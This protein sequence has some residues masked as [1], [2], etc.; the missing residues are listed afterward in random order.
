MVRHIVVLSALRASLTAAMD[1]D[2]SFPP[3]LKA[4]TV[5]LASLFVI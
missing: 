4:A 2:G 1:N 3:F 5:N